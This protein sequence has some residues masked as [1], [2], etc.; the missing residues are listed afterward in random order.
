MK[1]GICCLIHFLQA[2]G[3]MVM[4]AEFKQER[5]QIKSKF[6]EDFSKILAKITVI[7][8]THIME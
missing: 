1:Q 6:K 4:R 7:Q 8:S 5:L 2:N 3:S